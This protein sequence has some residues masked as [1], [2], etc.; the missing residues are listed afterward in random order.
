MSNL[1]LNA[2]MAPIKQEIKMQ[3][4]PLICSLSRSIFFYHFPISY[5]ISTFK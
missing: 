2:A 5:G 4:T 3:L 1:I